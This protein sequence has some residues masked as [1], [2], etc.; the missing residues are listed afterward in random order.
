MCQIQNFPHCNNVIHFWNDKGPNSYSV[1]GTHGPLEG[2]ISVRALYKHLNEQKTKSIEDER[3]VPYH[4]TQ[5]LT[6]S[7]H[8]GNA[9]C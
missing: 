9:Y 6:Y 7:W 3:Q 8:L 1:G 2:V 5:S 4:V